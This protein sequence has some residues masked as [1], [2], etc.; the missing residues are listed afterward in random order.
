MQIKWSRTT[1]RRGSAPRSL[2]QSQ[3]LAA[4]FG[5]HV[6]WRVRDHGR[7]VNKQGGR[8]RFEYDSKEFGFKGKDGKYRPFIVESAYAL[9]AGAVSGKEAATFASSA[10]FHKKAG[11]KPG[12]FKVTGGMWK[13]LTVIDQRGVSSKLFFGGSSRGMRS[14]KGSLKKDGTRR[15]PKKVRNRL[16]AR[17]VG[18]KGINVLQWTARELDSLLLALAEQMRL[19]AVSRLGMDAGRWSGALINQRLYRNARRYIDAAGGAWG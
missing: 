3:A 14:R 8:Q 16:K 5:D 18:N 15:A 1:K 9:E 6:R 13:G 12:A 2:K 11:S 19:D 4:A 10:D 17:S 7:P